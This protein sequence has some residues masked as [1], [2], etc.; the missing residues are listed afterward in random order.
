MPKLRWSD[1]EVE[2]LRTIYV[3]QGLE[4]AMAQLPG[5]PRQAIYVKA[6]K[7]GI[8]TSHRPVRVG[9][10]RQLGARALELRR[11]GLSYSAIGRELGMC[12]AAATNAVLHGECIA[13]GHRPI[14]RDANGKIT[15]E[16]V[17][18]IRLMLRKGLKH[19]DIQNW[20]GVSAATITRER[21]RYEVYL[22]ANGKAP[23]PPPGG[24]E[25]YSGVAITKEQRAHVEQLYLQGFG[26][27]KVSARSGVSRTHC[28]RIREKLIRRLK[29]RGECLPGCS[30]DGRRQQM[31]DHGRSIP[32]A[33]LNKLRALLLDGEPVARAARAAV[34]GGSTAYRVYHQLRAEFAAEG[35]ALPRKPWRGRHRQAVSKMSSPKL[36]GKRWGIDR[37]RMLVNA[38]GKSHEEAVAAVRAEWAEQLRA[39]PF[40]ER[41][42]LQLDNGAKIV[43][44]LRPV[45]A[46]PDVTLGG[47]ATAALG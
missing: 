46:V 4:A 22:K 8:H 36:P 10:Y 7:L 2:V 20:C 35:K 33:S 42:R 39:M 5:R 19:R 27:G 41:I 14:E 29:R 28:L 25:R 23:L 3:R 21:R 9:I 16:G 11:Q 34:V 15:R 40:E 45:R 26:A 1:E 17:E 43:A 18:R 24:G 37:Y 13:A 44:V 30:P 47:V 31:K 12:E 38:E 6:N 32:A